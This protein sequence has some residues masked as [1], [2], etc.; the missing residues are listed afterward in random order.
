MPRHLT[1]WRQC[2]CHCVVL[3]L[4]S[5]LMH[6]IYFILVVVL[7]IIPPPRRPHQSVSDWEV[8]SK[9]SEGFCTDSRQA[10]PPIPQMPDMLIQSLSWNLRGFLQSTAQRWPSAK[11]K[12]NLLGYPFCLQGRFRVLLAIVV[13]ASELRR[14]NDWTISCLYL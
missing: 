10:P 13:P 9:L 7:F 14:V 8:V 1:I 5:R 12:A 2:S 4:G 6:L 3:S 11:Y